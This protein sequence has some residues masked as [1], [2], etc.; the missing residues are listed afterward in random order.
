MMMEATLPQ[1]SA[2]HARKSA[3]TDISLSLTLD[4]SGKTDIQTGGYQQSR[5]DYKNY[6]AD[7]YPNRYY[8]A[9]GIRI[10]AN[11]GIRF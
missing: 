10:F 6:S 9:Q 1:R 3:E 7:K 5:F 2:R 11:V 8:Y 4:G